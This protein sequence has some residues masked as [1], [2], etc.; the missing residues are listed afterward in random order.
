MPPEV[1]MLKRAKCTTQPG[2]P[3]QS[4]GDKPLWNAGD[5]AVCQQEN[6]LSLPPHRLEVG[7]EAVAARLGHR[8]D[9]QRLRWP[10]KPPERPP[11]GASGRQRAGATPCSH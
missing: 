1:S 3:A 6:Q 2:Q 5:L 9:P 11:Q 4:P 7:G 10:A 8:P